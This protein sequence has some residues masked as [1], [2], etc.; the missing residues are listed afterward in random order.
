MFSLAYSLTDEIEIGEQSYKLDMSF[1]NIIRLI[2][3]IGDAELDDDIKVETGL[4]ML[5]GTSLELDLSTKSKVFH[6]IFEKAV[7]QKELKPCLDRQGNP[8]P[9]SESAKVYSLSQDAEYIYAS[10]MQDYGIDLFEQQGKM[11]WNKFKA[12]LSGLRND[13]KFKEVVQI[14]TSDLPKGKG[15]EKERQRMS[16]LKKTYE[17]KEE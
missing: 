17:L 16:E 15:T 4:E 11:H 8:M 5:I 7:A 2:D 10:F 9:E 6:Q 14:R 12:L 3:M 13:T 1:D